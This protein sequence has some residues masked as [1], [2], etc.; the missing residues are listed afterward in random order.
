[1]KV[2]ELVRGVVLGTWDGFWVGVGALL[3]GVTRVLVLVKI[4]FDAPTRQG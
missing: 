2:V 4:E 3:F 1:V